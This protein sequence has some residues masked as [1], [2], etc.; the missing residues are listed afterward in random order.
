M[1]TGR[2]IV[3]FLFQMKFQVYAFIFLRKNKSLLIC[4]F[5]L[6]YENLGRM[7]EGRNFLRPDSVSGMRFFGQNLKLHRN[8]GLCSCSLLKRVSKPKYGYAVF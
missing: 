7:K 6:I 3:C 4:S 1:D 5:L 8:E 2:F